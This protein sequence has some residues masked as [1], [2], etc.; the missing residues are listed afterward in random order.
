MI[1]PTEQLPHDPK[2]RRWTGRWFLPVVNKYYTVPENA[3]NHPECRGRSGVCI[4]VRQSGFGM[5]WAV[6]NFFESKETDG[7][8]EYPDTST[9]R[10]KF[11]IPCDGRPIK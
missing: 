9:V 8:Y 5:T 11:L 4:E 10:T 2:L 3:G 7:Q 6:I 1:L